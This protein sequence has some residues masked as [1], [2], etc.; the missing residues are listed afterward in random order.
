MPIEAN[1]RRKQEQEPWLLIF[2]NMESLLRR[3][4]YDMRE[5]WVK[6]TFRGPLGLSNVQNFLQYLKTTRVCKVAEAY[7]EEILL[8]GLIRESV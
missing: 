7:K 6:I 5:E 4:L 8:A 2:L 3:H 1:S